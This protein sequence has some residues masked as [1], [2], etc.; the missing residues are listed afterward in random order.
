VG[1]KSEEKRTRKNA[2]NE[3]VWITAGKWDSMPYEYRPTADQISHVYFTVTVRLLQTGQITEDR[4]VVCRVPLE[5]RPVS[6]K[7][8]PRVFTGWPGEYP[9]E[10]VRIPR[11]WPPTS[12]RTWFKCFSP[13]S[14]Y[15]RCHIDPSM[16]AGPRL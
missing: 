13:I 5:Y 6:R 8:T 2:N 12:S 3:G 15:Q 10:T 9:S 4:T 7:K 11:E 1:E 16:S 14:N